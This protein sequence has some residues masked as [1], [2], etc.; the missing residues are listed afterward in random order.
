MPERRTDLAL[1]AKELWEESAGQTTKLPGVRAGTR[2]MGRCT[3]T[4]VDILDEEGEKALGKPRG[5]YLTVELGDLNAEGGFEDAVET[6]GRQLKKLLPAKGAVLVAGLGNRAMTPDAVGPLAVEHLLVTRH[7]I[8]A[9]PN[10][11]GSFRAVSAVT[12]GVL[13]Q[14]GVES[15]EAVAAL[16][17]ELQPAAVIAVDA[18]AARRTER[19]CTTV[20]LSDTGI[21]PGSGVGNHRRKLDRETL[22]VPVIA[23]GV[24]TVVDAATIAA[25][26]L[27]NSSGEEAEG[28]RKSA[29]SMMVTPRDID[30]SVRQLGKVAGYAIN[31]ALQDMDI[32]EMTA[33]LT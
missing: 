5:R 13:G 14:S 12:P 27:G 32:S 18:L 28:L 9:L 8:S 1:E 4:K 33:L 7:L 17:R 6:V 3:V 24:P 20:Q 30:R 29:P 11:F 16:V 31:R 19:L 26:L 23:L 15:A 10:C 2:R 21:A 22:G 25:D